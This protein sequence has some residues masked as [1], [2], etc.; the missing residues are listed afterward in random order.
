ME[1]R[2]TPSYDVTDFPNDKFVGYIAE[3][4]V[5]IDQRKEVRHPLTLVCSPNPDR[6][7]SSFMC[8][9]IVDGALVPYE[10][11]LGTI[12]HI[13]PYHMCLLYALCVV[14]AETA[15]EA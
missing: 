4:D 5:Y 6:K 8:I 7:E 11:I 14:P 12:V 15:N 3:F 13:T 1:P 10:G 2:H 9:G